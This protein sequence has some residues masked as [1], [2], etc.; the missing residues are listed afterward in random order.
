MEKR[1]AKAK[2]HTLSVPLYPF[3]P[4]NNETAFSGEHEVF[5]ISGCLLHPNHTKYIFPRIEFIDNDN[6]YFTADDSGVNRFKHMFRRFVID[7]NICTYDEAWLMNFFQLLEILRREVEVKK[8]RLKSQ[9]KEGVC[10][11][12]SMALLHKEHWRSNIRKLAGRIEKHSAALHKGKPAEQSPIPYMDDDD[13]DLMNFRLPSSNDLP[14]MY[15]VLGWAIEYVFELDDVF[16]PKEVE[17]RMRTLR[18]TAGDIDYEKFIFH[19]VCHASLDKIRDY[20]AFAR[21]DLES[22]KAA[23]DKA[24]P[25]KPSEIPLQGRFAFPQD[26]TQ[27][28]FDQKDINIPSGPSV[29]ILRLLVNSMPNVVQNQDLNEASDEGR[30]GEAQ[31][32]LRSRIS[33]I[34][35]KLNILGI[36]YHIENK[37][38]SGYLM[39]EGKQHSRGTSSKRK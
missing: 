35:M 7:K 16:I 33:T 22:Y 5:L 30:S 1:K 28:L 39:R 14:W 37:R 2:P 27:A 3:D 17:E 32:Q 4:K 15:W 34:N 36:P 26:D 9:W 19:R 11:I 25:D 20:W 24:N 18:K 29:K 10:D 13:G 21:A 31:E 23:N 38:G 12:L 6:Y 8:D